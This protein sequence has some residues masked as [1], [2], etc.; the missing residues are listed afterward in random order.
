MLTI[1]FAAGV[2]VDIDVDTF[3]Y[4]AKKIGIKGID[5]VGPEDWP[6]LKKAWIGFLHVQWCR[7]QSD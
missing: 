7:N 2:L 4:E 1:R 5:L 6:V 3:V